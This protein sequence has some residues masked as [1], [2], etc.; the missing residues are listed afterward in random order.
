[1]Q[2]ECQKTRDAINDKLH[3]SVATIFKMWWDINKIKLNKLYKSFAG[4]LLENLSVKEMRK[5]VKI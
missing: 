1:V 4:N 3:S 2:H 5:S